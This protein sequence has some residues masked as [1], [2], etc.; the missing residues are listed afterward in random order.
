M[1]LRPR[2]SLRSLGLVSFAALALVGCS[3]P[4]VQP[5]ATRYYV[6][7]VAAPKAAEAA[8]A[9]E[10]RWRLGL[11][12]VDVPAFLRSKSIFVKVSGNE[13]GFVEDA[14]WAEP[15]AAG[16]E[17]VL[18]ESL[19]SRAE[20]AQVTPVSAANEN[21]RDLDVRVRVLRCE[22]DRAL[23]VARLSAAVEISTV[24][25][26]GE[27]RAREIVTAE[28]GDWDGKDYRALAKKL[29]DGVDALAEKICGLL[30]KE[31]R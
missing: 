7:S 27:R 15:L 3:L 11:H 17:R 23:G 22:G 5:D 18:R 25:V 9:P 20:I 6:L 4:Q 29:S 26:M 8:T 24:G 12:P 31:K 1:N 30:S 16:I 28:I 13:V 19:E 2:L 10:K 14:R 21:V